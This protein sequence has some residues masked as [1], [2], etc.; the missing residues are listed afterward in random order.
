MENVEE[1]K[2]AWTR[3]V[4]EVRRGER[5]FDDATIDE[6]N[7]YIT[8]SHVKI[9]IIS[10]TGVCLGKHKV[11]EEW[12]M[13]GRDDGWKIPAGICMFAFAS[14][15]PYIQMLMYGGSFPWQYD[16]DVWPAPCPD[17]KNPVVFELTR[18]DKT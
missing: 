12:I 11:G 13:K 17:S 1:N 7:K 4:E 6:V 10:Q 3:I 2:A 18:I 16:P 15:Y 9:K 14:I 5:E 8:N